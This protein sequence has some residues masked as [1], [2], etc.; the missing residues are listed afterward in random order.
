MQI[1]DW[2]YHG[3]AWKDPLEIIAENTGPFPEDALEALQNEGVRVRPLARGLPL[4]RVDAP[5]PTSS[6]SA[7]DP[8]AKHVT[9]LDLGGADLAGEDWQRISQMEHLTRLELQQSNLTD[10]ALAHLE[11]LNHLTYLNIH[12]TNVSDAGLAHLEVLH[13]LEKLYLWQTRVSDAG[14]QALRNALPELT[15]NR[16]ATPAVH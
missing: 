10:T 14:V 12:S 13:S 2:I 6:L 15:I 1:V 16:G 5:P 4:L 3:A 7:L 11:G 9:W 8:V